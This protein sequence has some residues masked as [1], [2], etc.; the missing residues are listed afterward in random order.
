MGGGEVYLERASEVLAREF[1]LYAICFHPIL[2][3]HLATRGVKVFYVRAFL[4]RAVQRVAKYPIC[5]VLVLYAAL[6]YNIQTVYINGCQGA[7]LAIL[8]RLLRRDT[9]LAPLH[10]PWDRCTLY[11]PYVVSARWAHRVINISEAIDKEHRAILPSV[12][13][14]AIPTWVQE[15]PDRLSRNPAQL[16]RTVLFIGRLVESKGLPDLISAIRKLQ[17]RV[18]LMIS[19][20][21]PLRKKC[22]ELAAGLPVTFLG[23]HPS[24]SELYSQAD[25]LIVPSHGPEGSCLVA[26]EA[27]A[28]GL[29]CIMSDIPVYR[30][31]AEGGKCALLVEPG[32]SD[33]IALAI[34]QLYEDEAIRLRIAEEAYAMVRNKY[35]AAVVW[36]AYLAAFSSNPQSDSSSTEP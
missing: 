13:T 24:L 34:Q 6:R 4:G 1:R 29:P 33:A 32:S 21:G 22:E 30:E 7:Y 12:R 28:H 18:S 27:M 15:I 9:I 23:H 25:A 11:L 36:P 10:L 17:G 2:A 5:A 35:S 26:I 14:V 31:I 3:E 19:G 20:N 16:R 8:A